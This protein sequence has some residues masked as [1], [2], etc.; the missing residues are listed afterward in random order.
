MSE[1]DEQ[2]PHSKQRTTLFGVSLVALLLVA[3]FYVASLLGCTAYPPKDLGLSGI[4]LFLMACVL[5]FG[6]DWDAMGL[7]LKKFGPLEFEQKLEGQSQEHV[8][9][10]AELEARLAKLEPDGAQPSGDDS[11]EDFDQLIINFLFEHRRWSFSP[12]RMEQWGADREGYDG[13]RNKPAVLRRSLRRLV[14]EGKLETRVSRKG[15]TL[16]TVS[17]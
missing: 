11:T 15:N 1:V 2:Q 12:V 4:I 3:G 5:L 14:A 7:S 13:L 8:V 10:I 16:Y 6:V 9:A 17:S